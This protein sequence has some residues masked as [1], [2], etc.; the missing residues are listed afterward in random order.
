MRNAITAV[1]LTCALGN[2]RIGITRRALLG[3]TSGIRPWHIP[4]PEGSTTRFGYVPLDE[5]TT[6]RYAYRCDAILADC[7]GQIAPQ[8]SNLLDRMDRKRIGI[9]LGTSNSV[10]DEYLSQEVPINMAHSALQLRQKIGTTGPAITVST[11]C[12]SSAKV[13]AT[14]RQLLEAEVCTAVIVGGIDSYCRSTVGGFH[15]L[16]STATELCQPMGLNRTGITLGEGAALLILEKA[17]GEI[18][19]CGVGESSDAYHLTAPNP[20]GEGA[21]TAMQR[22]LIDANLPKSS[23]GY[24]NLHGTGT[25]YNDRMESLAVSNLFG[26]EVA[27]SSTKPLTGHALGAAGAIEAALCIYM[28][29]NGDQLLPHVLTSACDPSLPPLHLVQV[30]ERREVR[31]VLSNSFAFGGSNATLILGRNV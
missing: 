1:G 6:N 22:A 21:Y 20:D 2:D 4:L 7:L 26:T 9:V 16:E 11:A 30:G 10:M 28:L 8:V 13:F 25:V 17:E 23:I 12:S 3:D 27:C 19:L 5:Q 18:N 15:A 29:L 24:I 31:Y 14:A